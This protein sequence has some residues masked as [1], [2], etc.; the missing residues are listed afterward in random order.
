MLWHIGSLI[1]ALMAVAKRIN[2]LSL[3]KIEDCKL[4]V[5]SKD[6]CS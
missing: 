1:I 3:N 5:E 6:V 4:S 2:R